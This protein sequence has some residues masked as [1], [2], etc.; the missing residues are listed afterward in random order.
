[1]DTESQQHS[2]D[3][4]LSLW[5][6]LACWDHYTTVQGPCSNCISRAA[7]SSQGHSEGHIMGETAEELEQISLE[8]MRREMWSPNALSWLTRSL[9]VLSLLTS[10]SCFP[11]WPC[12]WP[13]LPE[14]SPTDLLAVVLNTP[15]SHLEALHLLFYLP[16]GSPLSPGQLHLILWLLAPSGRSPPDTHAWSNSISLLQ[17]DCQLKLLQQTPQYIFCLMTEPLMHQPSG[18]TQKQEKLFLRVPTNKYEIYYK[19]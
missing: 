4:T 9:W 15:L 18:K 12:M 17:G 16:R 19:N 5:S 10:Q 6:P 1:M 13:P 8:N 3:S 14:S 11:T 7:L 2:Q